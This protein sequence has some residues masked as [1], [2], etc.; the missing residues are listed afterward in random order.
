MLDYQSSIYW[1]KR[2]KQQEGITFDWLESYDSL[3]HFLLRT[4]PTLVLNL[5]CGNSTLAEE[6]YDF[7]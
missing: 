1:N 3:K 5:G 7:G 6:I 4:K 2:Y